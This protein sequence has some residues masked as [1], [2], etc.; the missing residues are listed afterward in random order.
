MS[1]SKIALF[2]CSARW[3]HHGAFQDEFYSFVPSVGDDI[4]RRWRVVSAEMWLRVLYYI[5]TVIWGDATFFL[6]VTDCPS[7]CN[8]YPILNMKVS[9][10]TETSIYLY[11][12]TRRP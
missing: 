11:H 12:I 4:I 8:Y 2:S 3:S 5:Y 9:N 7:T 10:S 6:R 1:S